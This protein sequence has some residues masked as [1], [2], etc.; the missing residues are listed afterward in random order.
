MKRI[1]ILFIVFLSKFAFSADFYDSSTG[2]LTI[3]SV[4]VG[5]AVY[6]NVLVKIEDVISVGIFP[7]LTEND[8]YDASTNRLNIS[9]V[10]VGSSTYFNVIVTVNKVLSVDG[11]SS[12]ANTNPYF[13]IAGYT[14][15]SAKSI[16]SN[17]CQ[18]ENLQAITQNA[19]AVDLNLDGIKD[20][21]LQV[22]CENS[23]SG[24]P[25]TLPITNSLI[26]Y[27]S[28]PDGTYVIGNQKLF[29]TDRVDLGGGFIFTNMVSAD[30]N[31]DGYPDIGAGLDREDF[32]GQNSEGTAYNTPQIVLLSQGDGTYKVIQLPI[33]SASNTVQA[34]DNS[35]GGKDLVYGISINEPASAFR[36]KSNT[37]TQIKDYPNI[38]ATNFNFFPR[39][40]ANL[41]TEKLV[42]VSTDFNLGQASYEIQTIKNGNWTK[43]SS[44]S[45]PFKQVNI[46]GWNN[47]LG[48]TNMITF[49][50]INLS[51]G[52]FENSCLLRLTPTSNPI[53]LG[54]LTGSILPAN[55]SGEPIFKEG[56]LGWITTIV[57]FDLT[58]DIITP[59]SNII[60]DEVTN[61]SY[62]KMTCSDVNNDGYDDL[63]VYPIG[64]NPLG[65]DGTPIFYLNNKNNKLIR[66]NN[67]SLPHPPQSANGWANSSSIYEDLNGD[68]FK[69]LIYF[70]NST[71]M[72]N[73]SNNIVQVFYGKSQ[74]FN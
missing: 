41:G 74:I 62:T 27:L 53:L 14:L 63:V 58:N 33:I 1:K 65:Y 54:K 71:K 34:V 57:P 18:S 61:I 19:I 6:S 21:V 47:Q 67:T 42:S 4:I 49:N 44:Y 56:V 39:T 60:Q 73:P 68:G 5:K 26:V 16:Y 20:I 31:S 22:F 9:S 23:N 52:T 55:Y 35:I 17:L 48:V 32:R 11:L 12:L 38:N 28:Q 2:Q 72:D 40:A 50:G 25:S 36:F 43:T 69:D 46:M 37:F 66:V 13:K 3:P 24:V 10:K 30:F 7:A 64:S 15:P 8:T 29:G 59:L 51:Y 70:T 45:L